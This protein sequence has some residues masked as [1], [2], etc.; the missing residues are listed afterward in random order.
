MNM[1]TT[2]RVIPFRREM[3]QP[4]KKKQNRENEARG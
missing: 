3:P 2:G 1:V 4:L